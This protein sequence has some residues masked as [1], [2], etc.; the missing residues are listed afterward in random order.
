MAL[1]IIVWSYLA[2]IPYIGAN[3]DQTAAFADLDSNADS[4]V[5]ENDDNF[6]NFRVM[7]WTKMRALAGLSAFM[8]AVMF[9]FAAMA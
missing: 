8:V 7:R 9:G 3:G 2:T 1:L 4:M 6:A 5:N